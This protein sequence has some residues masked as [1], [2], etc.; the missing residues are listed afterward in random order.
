MEELLLLLDQLEEAI[1]ERKKEKVS[2][3]MEKLQE[4]DLFDDQPSAELKKRMER[5]AEKA[6]EM[7][8]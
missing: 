6:Q 1:K 8:S 2:S 4:V 3:V 7:F 5:L